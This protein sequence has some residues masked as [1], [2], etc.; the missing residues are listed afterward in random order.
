MKGQEYA[1]YGGNQTHRERPAIAGGRS[2]ALS[3]FK[4]K[5]EE[6]DTKDASIYLYR[7]YAQ[8]VN[9]LFAAI[10]FLFFMMAR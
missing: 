5:S 10:L 6:I 7:S 2:L 1:E 9:Q 4:I 3:I 8:R